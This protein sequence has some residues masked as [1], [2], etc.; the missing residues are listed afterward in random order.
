MYPDKPL[1]YIYPG[2]FLFDFQTT[3]FFSSSGEIGL[4]PAMSTSMD[5]LWICSR[6]NPKSTLY[7]HLFDDDM[8]WINSKLPGKSIFLLC[9]FSHEFR[10]D[11]LSPHRW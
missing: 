7:P 1:L 5:E 10:K 3:S 2:F 11:I 6:I 9:A 4:S 8:T